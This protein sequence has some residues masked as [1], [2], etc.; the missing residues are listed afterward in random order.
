MILARHETNNTRK[1]INMETI[2]D[3]PQD[4]SWGGWIMLDILLEYYEG[5]EPYMLGVA[6]RS[7]SS[8]AAAPCQ[9]FSQYLLM[10]LL[11]NCSHAAHGI[12]TF[13]FSEPKHDNDTAC[14]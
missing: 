13:R 14:C 5:L 4:A 11:L 6:A 9:I 3:A 1:R 10:F 8:T 7:N 12:F 2:K